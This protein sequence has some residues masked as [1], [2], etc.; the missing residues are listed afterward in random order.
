VLRSGNASEKRR[1]GKERRGRTGSL[2]GGQ[3]SFVSNSKHEK[4]R[5]DVRRQLRRKKK[6]EQQRLLN[7]RFRLGRRRG[8]GQYVGEGKNTQGQEYK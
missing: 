7:G 5:R 2:K 3:N 1:W 4:K 8:K 6:D